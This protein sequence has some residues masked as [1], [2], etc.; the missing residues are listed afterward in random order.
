M[1]KTVPPISFNLV[2]KSS[3]QRH[4]PG[5]EYRSQA[6]LQF[7]EIDKYSRQIEPGIQRAATKAVDP[8]AND[9]SPSI[10]SMQNQ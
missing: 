8:F 3:Q 1:L 7:K 6:G 5:F 10:N 9:S 4:C 2:L